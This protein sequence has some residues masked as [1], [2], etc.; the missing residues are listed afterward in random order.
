MRVADASRNHHC[1]DLG[2]VKHFRHAALALLRDKRDHGASATSATG[3]TRSVQVRLV[4][5]WS[6]RLD[7]EVN[8]VNVDTASSNVGRHENVDDTLRELLKV[9][10]ASSLVEVTV[11][12]G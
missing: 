1:L 4:L 2:T 5:V 11:Q 3:S 8:L 9:A 7:D 12:A 10:V 6:I